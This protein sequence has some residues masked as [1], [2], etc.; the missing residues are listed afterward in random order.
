[1]RT[2][3]AVL[4][5]LVFPGFGEGLVGRARAMLTWVAVIAALILACAI[6]VWVLPLVL[7][8]RIAAASTAFRQV[9]AAGRG[10]RSRWINALVIVGLYAALEIGSVAVAVE[11]FAIPSTAMAPT[12]AAGDHIFIEKLT[13]WVRP[14]TDGEV[15]VFRQ[16]CEPR[17]YI[18]RV[19]AV[20]GETVEVRC[21]VVYVGG[22]P[23]TSRLVQGAGCQYDDFDEGG[24]NWRSRPC[25]EYSETAGARS[26]RVY[27]D[28]ERPAIDADRTRSQGDD[29]DFP[30][31]GSAL[32]PPSCA[33]QDGAQTNQLAGEIVET[34]T[35]AGACEPQRHYVVP[36]GHVFVLG[37]NRANSNDSRYWGA[38]PVE[39]I[40]GRVV[41][42]W[43]SRGRSGAS[44]QR[45][46]GID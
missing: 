24:G 12:L 34:G 27:H 5:S 20:A 2:L 28:A 16:P 37:D 35:G 32:E 26:Y 10:T 41:G 29:K 38:V 33:A 7:A 22:T 11:S 14:I 19:V 17:D 21:H 39:N 4:G 40:T 43:G 31:L 6:S 1:M 25:S 9:R 13:R 42:I 36:P 46:G 23:R 8:A 45:F 44:L 30:R 3:I 15:V 18:K